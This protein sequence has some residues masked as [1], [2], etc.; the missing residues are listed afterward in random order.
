MFFA[1][2]SMKVPAT[3][4]SLCFFAL[5]RFDFL[6]SPAPHVDLRRNSIHMSVLCQFHAFPTLFPSPESIFLGTRNM[7]QLWNVSVLCSS[8]FCMKSLFCFFFLLCS[9]LFGQRTN[10]LGFRITIAGIIRACYVTNA[11]ERRWRCGTSRETCHRVTRT[12]PKLSSKVFRPCQQQRQIQ[13]VPTRQS[14]PTRGRF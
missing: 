3:D 6:F 5:R 2:K 10:E 14:M 1:G 7:S 11:S 9:L 13:N 4:E 12:T 8:Y